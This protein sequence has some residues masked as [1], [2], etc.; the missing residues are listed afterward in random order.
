MNDQF[1]SKYGDEITFK[2]L[3]DLLYKFSQLDCSVPRRDEGRKTD[4]VERESLKIYME[5]LAKM[6][7]WEYPITVK[8]RER[9]DFIISQDSRP[10][11]GIEQT[12][13]TTNKIQQKFAKFE[14]STLE[15]FIDYNAPPEFGNREVKTARSIIDMITKKTLKLNKPNYVLC[16]RNELLIYTDMCSKGK[17]DIALEYLYPLYEDSSM[18]I[19]Y[20]IL[21]DSI[22][23]IFKQTLRHNV[24]DYN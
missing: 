7:K 9:P 4:H 15:I 22:S 23:I 2:D 21:F 20:K 13:A 8:K 11:I 24:I 3:S 19:K 12:E 5:Q 10:T 17:E 6:D 18:H 14:R 1:F 16:D